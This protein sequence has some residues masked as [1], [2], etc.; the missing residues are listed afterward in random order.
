MSA[1]CHV[2]GLW[3]SVGSRLPDA[4]GPNL[5]PSPKSQHL[6][7]ASAEGQQTQRDVVTP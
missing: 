4:L 6:E 3:E 7:L 1:P 2:A 5:F